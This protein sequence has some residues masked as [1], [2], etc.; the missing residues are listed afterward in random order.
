MI[1]FCY[2]PQWAAYGDWFAQLWAESLGKEG[3]GSQ[4]VPA[5]GVTDQHSINQMFLS[6]PRNKACLFLT[7]REQVQ[8][9]NFG[10]DVPDQWAWLR[11]KPFGSLLEAEALGTRMALCKSGVPLLHVEMSERTPRAAGALMLMLEAATLFTGWLMDI[12]PLDQPAVELGK[13]LANARLGATG[14][15][16][17][18]ADMEEFLSAPR[19][20][21]TF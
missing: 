15:A 1:F 2:I 9:R 17:E 4:P 5:T 8:G 21:Q 3:Q 12:N 16:Q 13:R 11:A 18:N 10:M 6:G 7:S 19:V 20:E 14:Y